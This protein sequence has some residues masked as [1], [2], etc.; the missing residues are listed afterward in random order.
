MVVKDPWRQVRRA[1]GVTTFVRWAA[2]DRIPSRTIPAVLVEVQF[3]KWKRF[4]FHLQ[5]GCWA[6]AWN[7][8]CIFSFQASFICSGLFRFLIGTSAKNMLLTTPISEKYPEGSFWWIYKHNQK[9]EWHFVLVIM[10][11]FIEMELISVKS[12]P[13]WPDVCTG[14][15]FVVTTGVRVVGNDF[16][17]GSY[18]FPVSLLSRTVSP[19]RAYIEADPVLC[20]ANT[21]GP[22][23]I[24]T[25]YL[26]PLCQWSISCSV[27]SKDIFAAVWC[28]FSRFSAISGFLRILLH[29]TRKKRLTSCIENI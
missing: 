5:H 12:S 14:D 25:V 23:A 26:M 15:S 2:A 29:T 20:S 24:T 18:Y 4:Y 11:F 1:E 19:P 22:D 10:S 7:E 27:D 17:R 16:L 21:F 13:G 6:V 28:I 8:G 9:V 3:W